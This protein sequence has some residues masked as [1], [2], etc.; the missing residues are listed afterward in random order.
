MVTARFLGLVDRLPRPR[1]FLGGVCVVQVVP[2]VAVELASAA[3]VRAVCDCTITGTAPKPRECF[4]LANGFFPAVLS[5]ANI[6]L[7][8]QDAGT[9]PPAWDFFSHEGADVEAHAVI[10]VRLPADGLLVDGFPADE[11][12][13]GRLAVEY[14]N[15]PPLQFK[16]RDQSAFRAAIASV[17]TVLLPVDPV[18]KIAI[19]EGL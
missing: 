1:S 10:D 18:A 15:E 7:G 5:P 13:E 16:R 3:E 17:H 2:A 9:L 6:R 19:G 8:A 4:S 14:G 12:V 11:D